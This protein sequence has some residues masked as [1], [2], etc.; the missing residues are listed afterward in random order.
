MA[1]QPVPLRI[2]D[3]RRIV[4]IEEPA[5][6]PDGRRIAFIVVRPD[7]ARATYRNE[8]WIVGADGTGLRRLIA[9][10]D[11]SVP[12][13]SPDGSTLAYLIRY[14]GHLQVARYSGLGRSAVLSAAANDVDDFAW[15]PDGRAIAFAAY[16]PVAQRDYFAPGDSDY[17]LHAPIA[18]VHLWLMDA[19]GGHVRRLTHGT[20]S[21]APTDPGG[22][23]TSQFA[24]SANGRRLYF[25]RVRNTETGDDEY[26]RIQMLDV[27]SGRIRAATTKS[28]YA[29]SPQPDGWRLLYSY[30]RRGNYLAEN[31]IHVIAG[32]QDRVISRRLDRNIGGAAWLSGGRAILACGDDGAHGAAW[33]IGVD[34]RVRRI[35]FGGLTMTCDSYS[36]STFDCG[37][38]ASVARGGAIA[39]VATDRRHARE[40]YYVRSL[41]AAPVRLTHFND[42][43]NARLIGR[44]TPFSWKG[45]AQEPETGVLV[46][47]P[48][49]RA[50]GRY[51]IVVLIHGGPGL[52]SIDSFV[53]ESWPLAELIA[54]HGYV[55]FEPNYRGSD[56][57]GNAFMLAIYRDT[58]AGPSRD[59][60]SGLE[61]VKRLPHVDPSRVA[62]GGWSYGGLLTSWII[63]HDHEFRAAVSGAA[64]NDE[65]EEYDLST[66]NVQNRYYLGTSPHVPGG[67]AVYDS[68]SPIAYAQDVRTPTFIWSTTGDAVVPTTMSYSMYHALKE[69]HVPV[70]FVEFVAPSH[71]P[72]TPVM[73][74]ELSRMWIDWFDHYLRD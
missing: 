1:R 56:D 26:S 67:A 25:T 37:I 11:V 7:Y 33:S 68:Q 70:K 8:L 58:V 59:I 46:Y 36:S 61:A 57:H 69:N 54:S 47:P 3:S 10:N 72:D 40:L 74:E 14:R 2:E 65:T 45:P 43:L 71:G 62:I 35:A 32:G 21:V 24:W 41:R 52:A 23:F 60:L 30:P 12:R 27:A 38:A 29:F 16:D 53:W 19:G 4:T 17:T 64:V 49:M 48:A 63:E 5:I 6:A 20:W 15:R 18:P 34:A 13:W 28:R 31:E 42:F 51:P 22:I 66:S 44:V 50:G 73:V 55:V 39:F 9:G